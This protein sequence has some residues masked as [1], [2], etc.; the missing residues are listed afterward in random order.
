MFCTSERAEF[1]Y[2]CIL[3][4]STYFIALLLVLGAILFI[5]SIIIQIL[6]LG[7][8]SSW[9]AV[10]DRILFSALI[11]Y[12]LDVEAAVLEVKKRKRTL[13]L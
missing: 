10:S 9:C 5:V 11:A 1:F 2:E 6:I 3:E 7:E 4:V 12:L 13:Y 8:L